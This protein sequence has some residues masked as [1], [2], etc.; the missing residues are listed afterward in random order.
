MQK[1]VLQNWMNNCLENM[2]SKQ[3]T[4]ELETVLKMMSN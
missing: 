4:E 1:L 2:S 3:L